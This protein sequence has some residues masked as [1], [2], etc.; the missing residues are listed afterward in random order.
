[1]LATLDNTQK[2]KARQ[3]LPGLGFGPGMMH[4]AFAGGP[5]FRH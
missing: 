2:T 1:L 4:G 3:I 5:P